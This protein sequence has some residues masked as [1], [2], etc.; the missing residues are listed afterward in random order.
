[1]KQVICIRR[2]LKMRRGK[3]CAQAA[4][5]SMIFLLKNRSTF[6]YM[7]LL[8]SRCLIAPVTD[9]QIEWL[10]SAFTKVCVKVHSEEELLDIVKKAEDAG[11]EANPVWDS[12]RT[13]FGGVRTLTAAAIGPHK[14]DLIDSITGHLELL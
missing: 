2:D 5:A 8:Q 10:E 1:M 3:E 7:T 11:I 9:E 14:E 13:E 6:P 4:H 12:G